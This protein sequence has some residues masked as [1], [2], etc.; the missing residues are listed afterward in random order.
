[1]SDAYDRHMRQ[2]A[3]SA[4]KQMGEQ[5]DLQEGTYVMLAGPNFETVAESRLLRMLGADAV[6]EK[7]GLA[8]G[9]REGSGRIAKRRKRVWIWGRMNQITR[10]VVTTGLSFDTVSEYQYS[11]PLCPWLGVGL[12][13]SI[14]TNDRNRLYW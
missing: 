6:G 10:K 1:M 13:S 9:L 11:C 3:L 4:W 8:G 12:I 2:K 14:A 7:G 5:R